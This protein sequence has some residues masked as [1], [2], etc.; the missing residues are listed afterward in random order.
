MSQK[1]ELTFSEIS[2]NC[3]YGHWGYEGRGGNNYGFEWTCRHKN[4]VPQG[5]SWG[6]CSERYCPLLPREITNIK[7]FN[8]KGELVAT[9]DKGIYYMNITTK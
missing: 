4:N 5:H 1:Y 8:N 3:S 6:V 9:A 2:Y 7:I